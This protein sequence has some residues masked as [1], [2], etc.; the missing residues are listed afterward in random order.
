MNL[1]TCDA[2]AV[3]TLTIT[4]PFGAA[5]QARLFVVNRLIRHNVANCIVSQVIAFIFNAICML[6]KI[7]SIT[8]FPGSF[9]CG[10][11]TCMIHATEKLNTIIMINGFTR[12][13]KEAILVFKLVLWDVKPCN[14]VGIYQHFGMTP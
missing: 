1:Q 14:F 10:L 2:G 3:H 7:Y 6:V 13:Q 9:L 12:M 4:T 5:V 11:T 8:N